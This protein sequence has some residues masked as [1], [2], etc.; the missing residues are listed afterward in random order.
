[1]VSNKNDVTVTICYLVSN[2]NDVTVTAE[3]N[4]YIVPFTDQITIVTVTPLLLPAPLKKWYV[5]IVPVACPPNKF[6]WLDCSRYL[7]PQKIL[8]DPMF[9]LLALPKNWNGYIVTVSWHL[10][11]CNSYI[12]LITNI[13]LKPLN[14]SRFWVPKKGCW[15]L[16]NSKWN[17]KLRCLKFCAAPSF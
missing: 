11:R 12:V 5:S 3:S 14:R 9:L 17:S 8:N 15:L 1:M 4:D 2:G 7:S 13:K 10:K 6:K 16:K